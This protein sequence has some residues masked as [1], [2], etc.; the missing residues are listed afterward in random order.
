MEDMTNE[1]MKKV[2]MPRTVTKQSES[3]ISDDEIIKKTIKI[4]EQEA[5]RKAGM[6]VELSEN[7]PVENKDH[8]VMTI[9][10]EYV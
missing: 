9:F 8:P 7:I 3:G 1:D 10:L 2:E 4:M 5:L 6:P